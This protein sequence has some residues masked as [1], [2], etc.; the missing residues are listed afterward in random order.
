MPCRLGNISIDPPLVLA[1]MAGITDQYFRL[2]L[3]RLGGLGLVTMEFISSEALTRGVERTRRMVTFAD[4]EHPISIQIYGSRPERMA[5]AARLVEEA[6]ADL[7]DINMGCPANKVLKGCAGAGLMRDLDN[8]REIVRAVRARVR[9]PVTVKFRLGITDREANFLELGRIC[10]EEG[11]DGVTLHPRTARQMFGGRAEW[12]RIGELKA[13]LSIPVIGNGD[14]VAPADAL[15]MFRRT[16]CDAVMIGRACLKN[17]WIFAQAAA[18]LR[19]E[20]IGIPSTEQRRELIFRHFGRLRECEEEKAALHKFRTFAG[21]YTHGLP[22]GRLLRQKI[23]GIPDCASFMTALEEF[24]EGIPA[25]GGADPGAAPPAGPAPVDDPARPP[26][27]AYSDIR[28]G[29]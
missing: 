26:R 18:A 21:W 5:D 7:V 9:I 29:L 22:G 8:A 15:E 6:G 11:A 25:A 16:G 2:I 28:G 3:K 17:P 27:D 20:P 4:E 12:A 19:G 10:Q 14:V 13:R 24:F 1:P 23:N